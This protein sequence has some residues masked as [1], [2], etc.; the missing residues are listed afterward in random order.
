MA[1]PPTAMAETTTAQ[2]ETT[3]AQA[4]EGLRYLHRLAER[5]HEA[6]A[7]FLDLN[8]DEISLRREQQQAAMRWLVTALAQVSPLPLSIDSS[9]V[10]IIRAGLEAWAA[11]RRAPGDDGSG[12]GLLNSASLERLDALD[13]ALAHDVQVVVTAA[14]ESGMPASAEERVANASRVIEAALAKGIPLS[15]LYVDPLVFPIGVDQGFGHHCL[16]AITTLRRRY[17]AEIHISGGFSNVSFGMPARQADQ[18]RVP[19]AG[20]RGRRRQR[21]PGSGYQPA[22]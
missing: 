12:R 10:D 3:T 2:A 21:D 19:A 9:N 11:C 18:R 7:H 5:Q 4:A 17:G 16:Q 15:D 1:E 13:L 22:G 14:G 20:D 6:G 8:V